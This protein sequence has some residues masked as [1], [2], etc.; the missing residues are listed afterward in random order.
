[1][2]FATNS[3]SNSLPL[4]LGEV[5]PTEGEGEAEHGLLTLLL[6]DSRVMVL[7]LILPAIL[8]L[9]LIG[10]GAY[11]EGLWTERWVEQDNHLLQQFS[12]SVERSPQEFGDWTSVETPITE[13]EFERTGCKAYDSRVFRHRSTGDEV[14]VYVVSGTARHITI[15]TPDWCYVGAGFK[16]EGKPQSH[17]VPFG[18]SAGEFKTTTFMKTD[19]TGQQRLRIFWAYS[20]DGKWIGP[21]KEKGFF[22]GRPA[23]V[24][25]YLIS[26]AVEGEAVDQSPVLE[27]AR[28]FMPRLTQELF[29]NASV[30]PT[31]IPAAPSTTPSTTPSTPTPGPS[32]LDL[33][34]L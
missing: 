24:K 32:D 18:E 14:S 26:S 20:D 1:M 34:T 30:P 5:E 31:A 29:V 17:E 12:A 23:L 33:S 21:R 28:E 11:Y 13:E 25:V 15:H 8:V 22:A 7:R 2:H 9:G 27:F 16:M 10:V 3:Q 6:S 4:P 19:A